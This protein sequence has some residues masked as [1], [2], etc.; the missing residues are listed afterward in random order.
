MAVDSIARFDLAIPM[1]ELSANPSPLEKLLDWHDF[2][3]IHVVPSGKI[4]NSGAQA[5]MAPSDYTDLW[6][7]NKFDMLLYHW[8]RAIYLARLACTI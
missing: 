1:E 7:A 5:E 2:K 6:N 4:Q 8:V 3:Q